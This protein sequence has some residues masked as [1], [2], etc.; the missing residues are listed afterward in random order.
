[1]NFENIR[2]RFLA[3]PARLPLGPQVVPDGPLQVALHIG[4]AAVPLLDGLQPYM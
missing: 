2:K 4:K 1:M 3:E